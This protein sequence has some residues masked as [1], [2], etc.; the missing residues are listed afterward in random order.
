MFFTKSGQFLLLIKKIK[1]SATFDP[2]KSPIPESCL[3]TNFQKHQKIGFSSDFGPYPSFLNSKILHDTIMRL[4]KS[5][6]VLHSK[7]QNG[8][9]NYQITI[10]ANCRLIS[11]GSSYDAGYTLGYYLVTNDTAESICFCYN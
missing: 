5:R 6:Y 9:L 1:I 3:E 2:P 11:L 10:I 8:N 4:K 7:N